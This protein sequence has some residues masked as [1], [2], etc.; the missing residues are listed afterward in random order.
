MK[1][2][3]NLQTHCKIGYPIFNMDNNNNKIV[4]ITGASS[5]IG[6]ATALYLNEH[7]YHVVA[8]VRKPQDKE[9][10]LAK[11]QFPARML[12]ILL[13]VTKESDLQSALASVQA[14]VAD[15]KEV[16]A[17]VSNAGIVILKGNISCEE[18][19]EETLRTVMDINFFGAVRF[20]QTFLPLVR[21]AK[22]TVVINSA[23]AA[24]LVIPFTAGYATSK[25]ALQG[26]ATSLR[27]EVYA[28][29]IHVVLIEAARASTN[30]DAKQNPEAVDQSKLYPMQRPFIKA[31]LESMA[32]GK[33][34]P[35]SSPWRIA[36]TI[37]QAIAAKHPKLHYA[38]GSG[39]H[40]LAFIS[41]L[42]DRIQD[43]LI[44]KMMHK[45]TSTSKLVT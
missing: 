22:G 8:G 5:G 26:W 36:K 4:V 1:K 18:C 30:L 14:L 33:N 23:M 20:I 28:Q 25:C 13:D 9:A 27:R 7:G 43:W 2:Q 3:P 19:P 39:G 35:H 6:L 17:I 37:A 16:A 41:L 31:F 15:H 38:I 21:T 12:T 10:V 45:M 40:L 29:G 34:N 24:K 11:A 42:P 44:N 32:S